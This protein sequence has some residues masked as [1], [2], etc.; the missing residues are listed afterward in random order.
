MKGAGGPGGHVS[1]TSSCMISIIAVVE[2]YFSLL[3]SAAAPLTLPT[4]IPR[5]GYASIAVA[6]AY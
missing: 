6:S 5:G 2:S 1:E 4:C 3:I